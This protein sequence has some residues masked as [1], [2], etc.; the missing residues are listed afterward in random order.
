MILDGDSV[1]ALVL[2][3]KNFYSYPRTPVTYSKLG[4]LG[5]LSTPPV[6]ESRLSEAGREVRLMRVLLESGNTLGLGVDENTALVITAL[7][8]KP[9]ATV[10]SFMIHCYRI[11]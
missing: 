3:S 8:T 5:F 11:E 7:L 1:S 9:I 4:G 2:G 6:I 10:I